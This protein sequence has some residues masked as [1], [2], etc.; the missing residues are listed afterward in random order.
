MLIFVVSRRLKAKIS[1][2]FATR[3][4]ENKEDNCYSKRATNSLQY[5]HRI[6]LVHF[7]F[8]TKKNNNK[9]GDDG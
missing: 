5:F 1:R 7:W 6:L 3:L 9:K 4:T 2:K 8:A